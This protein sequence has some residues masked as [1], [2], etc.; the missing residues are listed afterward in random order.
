MANTV[1][2][3][4][5]DTTDL[6]RAQNFYAGIFDWTFRQFTDNMLTIGCGDSHVGGL[7]LV[8][9]VEAGKSPSIWIQVDDI[10]QTIAKAQAQGG[11]VVTEK[12]PVPHV[13]WSAQFSDLDGNSV[14][15]V[16]FENQG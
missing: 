3:V 1:C 4:E 15:I 12:G 16:Q 10:D 14:G 9:S 5:L 6:A 11:A 2:H 8:E 7:M 13:G